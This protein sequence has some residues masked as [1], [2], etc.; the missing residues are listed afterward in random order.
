ML[1]SDGAS[2]TIQL[3]ASSARQLEIIFYEFSYELQ[4]SGETGEISGHAIFSNADHIE[5]MPLT[6][7]PIKLMDPK[8]VALNGIKS[9]DIHWTGYH[10]A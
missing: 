8:D 6:L 5:P 1:I 9:P 2:A 3:R 7:W 10:K 4:A